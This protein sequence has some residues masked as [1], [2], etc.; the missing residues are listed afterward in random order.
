LSKKFVNGK[1]VR[2]ILRL[3][4]MN[5]SIY[6]NPLLSNVRK[7]RKRSTPSALRKFVSRKQKTKS[8]L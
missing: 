4:R 1:N 8:V 5:D 7:K 3:F 2:T 6:F